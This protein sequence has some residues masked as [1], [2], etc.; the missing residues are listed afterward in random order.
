MLT[1]I[2]FATGLVSA[3]SLVSVFFIRLKQDS[4]VL[5]AVLN[6]AIG[7]L[8]AVTFLDVIP[9]VFTGADKSDVTGYGLAFLATSIVF[10]VTEKTLCWHHCTHPHD[11][12]GNRHHVAWINLM[13]SGIHNFADG[14]AIAA[15]FSVSWETG[16]AA[17]VAIAAHE[18][19]KEIADFAVLI[20]AGFSRTKAILWN[21]GSALIAIAGGTVG[22]FITQTHELAPYLVSIAGGSFLY[23]ALADLT[24]EA[25]GKSTRFG[26]H[27]AMV[28][29]GALMIYIIKQVLPE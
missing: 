27:V 14:L 13:G 6:F 9:E 5:D 18:L 11:D 26:L 16:V 1:E 12:A 24:P 22:Y 15:G 20:H 3:V 19:P 8:L 23:L 25:H 4:P 21:F 17:T 2:L 7:T 10:F 28:I 29:L